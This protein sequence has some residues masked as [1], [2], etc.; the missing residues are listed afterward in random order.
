MPRRFL[1]ICRVGDKS[2]HPHWLADKDRNFDIFL[3]YFGNT[4]DHYSQDAEYYEQVK[5]PKWP[6]LHRI[7][8]DNSAIIGQYDAV[9]LPDDDLLADTQTLNRLFNLFMALEFQ[10]AQPAL[11]IDSHVIYKELIAQPK[12]LARRTNFVEV[13]AP[14]FSRQALT[15]LAPT[16]IQSPSGWGL[17]KLWPYLLKQHAIG[18]L[19]AT[20]VTHTRPVG[21]EL[22][23]NNQVNTHA[24]IDQLAKLYPA[25][26]INQKTRHTRF[27]VFASYG[28]VR[29]YKGNC[30]RFMAICQR[31][32][33]QI[34]YKNHA[35]YSPDNKITP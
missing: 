29:S 18:V 4:P 24:D 14:I 12:L 6:E 28:Q 3:S 32:R 1:I 7:I 10:L 9:W 31:I 26:T 27:K 15:H 17:D 23:K 34:Q 13:M 16:F 30:A 22:Y 8:N 25:A 19:D 21:G 20:P 11:T 5:G 33:A 2:L 35:R